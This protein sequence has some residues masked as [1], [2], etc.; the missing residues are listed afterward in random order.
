MLPLLLL[1]AGATTSAPTRQLTVSYFNLAQEQGPLSPEDLA[2]RQADAATGGEAVAAELAL[3]EWKLCVLDSLVRWAPLKEGP[4]TLVDG[5]YGRCG[6]LERV[7]RS[8]LMKI[9]QDGR[10]IVDL[11]LAKLMTKSL[12]DAWRL[13]LIA[14]ALDQ[15]LAAQPVNGKAGR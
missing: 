6:D 11:N 1:A 14:T 3:N 7:Y 12:E 5:A 15:A 2:A 13:R 8:H 9:S 10:V 4:G